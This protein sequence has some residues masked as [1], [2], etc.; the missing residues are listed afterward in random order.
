MDYETQVVPVTEPIIIQDTF[1]TALHDIEDLGEGNFRFVF[2]AK[3]RSSYD[4]TSQEHVVVAKLVAP[5]MTVFHAAMWAL[6]AI[7]V[8][9]CAHFMR[10]SGLH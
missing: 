8:K 1:V 7:G 6:K 3:Q 2:I 5:T 10:C 4:G 9:C